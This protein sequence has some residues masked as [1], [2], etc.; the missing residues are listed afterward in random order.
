[1]G[2]KA[3][4]LQSVTKKY[5]TQTGELAVLSDVNLTLDQ[6]DALALVGASG[7]G[8]STLLSIIAG[9]ERPSSGTVITAGIDLGKVRAKE[10]AA[11]RF[12][13]IGFIFQQYHLIPTLTAI[14]NVMLPCV[15]WKVDYNP[16]QRAAELLDLVGL[17]SRKDH[18]P[19]QLSGGEQQRVCIARALIN[20]PSLLLADEP[21]G[22]LDDESATEV[23]QLIRTLS[24]EF[25]MA[26]L[27]VTH[28]MNLART[29]ERVVRLKQ[30]VLQEETA[31]VSG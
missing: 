9:L 4:V 6:G 27:M 17:G 31:Q 30:G 12:R 24:E 11:F 29:F 18:L 8:K 22:N 23:F 2:D 19:A 25:Q 1:M 20:R 13:H 10:L 14:E 5:R 15:P 3:I 28:D 7:A 26:L 16:R 21:T